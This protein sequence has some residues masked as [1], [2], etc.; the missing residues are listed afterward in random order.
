M[1]IALQYFSYALAGHPYMGV[2]RNLAYRKSLFFKHKGF[3]SHLRFLSGDDDLFVNE[4][5]TAQNTRVEFSHESHTIS[6]PKKTSQYWSLQKQRHLSTS[7]VYKSNDQFSLGTEYASRVLFYLLTIATIVLFPN[8][9][10]IVVSAFLVRTIV[11]LIIF[12]ITMKRLNEKNL[13]LP[14]LLF[15]VIMP[16]INANFVITNRFSSNKN[17]WK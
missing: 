3:A 8:V 10:G 14:S 5:A 2:G 1:T 16:Y 11:Q 7:K 9:A 15:D 17:R 4:A 12:K 13:L 6:E